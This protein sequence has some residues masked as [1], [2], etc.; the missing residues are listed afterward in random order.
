ML[1]GRKFFQKLLRAV[2]LLATLFMVF[3]ILFIAYFTFNQSISAEVGDIVRIRTDGILISLVRYDF[4]K[5][6]TYYNPYIGGFG[7]AEAKEGYK[8]LII[9]FEISSE[10]GREKHISKE[11]F[12]LVD[13]NGNSFENVPYL[14]ANAIFDN[15]ISSEVFQGYLVYMVPEMIKEYKI[16]FRYGNV[17]VEWKIASP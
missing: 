2:T 5:N 16:T 7:N 17:G 13:L 4:V 1:K 3:I 15:L 6:Y 8:F 11:N 10:D 12:K 9:L 14:G